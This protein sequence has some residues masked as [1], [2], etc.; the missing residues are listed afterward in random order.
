MSIEQHSK[1]RFDQL[2]ELVR[3]AWPIL[4]S[5]L[6]MSGMGVVDT[7]MAGSVSSIDLAAVAV[8]FSLWLP[9]LMFMVGLFS[10]TSS[11]VA[12]A[13]GAQDP[14]LAKLHITQSL[15]LAVLLGISA[16]ALV[17]QAPILLKAMDIDPSV[18][19][20][21]IAYL[22]AMVL[23]LPAATLYQVLRASSEGTGHSK[24][25]MQ[26]NLLAFFANIPLNFIFVH[27]YFGIPAMGGAGCGWATAT[28]MWINAF[29]LALYM[30]KSPR[31]SELKL[32]KGGFVPPQLKASWQILAL[33]L[34]IGAAVFAEVVIFSIIALLIGSLGA[35]V[36]AGHQISMNVSAITFM[37]PLSVSIAITVQVG[38][39]L[40][41]K[42][43]EDAQRTWRQAMLLAT[44][45]A[46][47]N[48]ILIFLFAWP[49]TG[50]YS[51]EL[52]IRELATGLLLFAAAYQ[53]SDALQVAAAGA[54]RG[55]KDTQVTMYITL[56]AY[57]GVGLPLGYTLGLTDFITPASGPKGFWISLLI[58][59]SLAAV[60]LVWRLQHISRKNL[61]N[62]TTTIG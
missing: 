3:L 52:E 57:W 41:A 39:R 10:A 58:S 46:S 40:G 14:N 27:G 13:W 37:L 31:F 12:H 53:I 5:Q 50:I 19:P 7:I 6:A 17:T 29:A 22:D 4:I 1:T 47:T 45:I 24:P 25:V 51:K 54:L 32:F 2:P 28:V 60:L 42:R 9:I 55:Y 8:A 56:F 61:A 20:I 18:H 26:M 16:A 15:W 48:A 34:P 59:L 49:I 33:G 30:H 38:Q 23:G 36:I 43:P 62:I 11:L 44:A 21:V 35:T